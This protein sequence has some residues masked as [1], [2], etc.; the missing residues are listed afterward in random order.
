[1]NRKHHQA[2]QTGFTHI[3]FLLAVVF[4]GSLLIFVLTKNG[5][6]GSI[7]SEVP[8]N[9]VQNSSFENWNRSMPQS[10]NA[11]KFDVSQSSD[12][13]TGRY[14]LSLSGFNPTSIASS[15][16]IQQPAVVSQ[17]ISGLSANTT[18]TL[19]LYTK[20]GGG[21]V[22]F[23]YTYSLNGTTGKQ[24]VNFPPFISSPSYKITSY[25]FQLPSNLNSIYGTLGIKSNGTTPVQIDDISLTAQ[26]SPPPPPPPLTYKACQNN[27]CATVIGVGTSTCSLDTDCTPPPTTYKTCQNNACA[28][29][30]GVGANT[31]ATDADCTPPPSTYRTCQNNA[32]VT[33]TGTGNSSCST[34]ADCAPAGVL[35]QVNAPYFP[36]TGPIDNGQ[37]YPNNYSKTAVFWFGTVNPNSAYTD[38][39]VGYNDSELFFNFMTIDSDLQYEQDRTSSS[40]KSTF[41]QNDSVSVFLNFAGTTF[42]FDSMMH[43][44]E[45][46]TNYQLAY[47]NGQ[48]TALPFTTTSIWRG[49]QPDNSAGDNGWL[50][51]IDIPWSSLGLTSAP[52]KGTM[53]KIAAVTHNKNSDG[54]KPDVFWPETYSTV[55]PGTWGDLRFGEVSYAAPAATNQQTVTIKN[56]PTEN[57]PFS[58]SSIIDTILG[59]STNCGDPSLHLPGSYNANWGYYNYGYPPHDDGGNIQEY[60]TVQN[61]RDPGDWPCFSKYIGTYKLSAIPAGKKIVKAT[62]TLSNYGHSGWSGQNNYPI[63]VHILPID[64][65]DPKAAWENHPGGATGAVTQ[66]EVSWN[67]APLPAQNIG[68]TTNPIPNNPDGC[69][70]GTTCNTA[71]YCTGTG[72]VS[73]C[74]KV[75]FDLSAAVADAY[76]AGQPLRFFLYTSDFNL[77]SGEY[78]ISSTRGS[79]DSQDRPFLTVTFGE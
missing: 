30:T 24:V 18:Y 73:D 47:K 43:W 13:L 9:L 59:G 20:G 27:A 53:W 56:P 75:N 58:S 64:P 68:S 72:H 3:V 76:A 67:N 10:W 42:R 14:A 4:I 7:N 71:I 29:V 79:W 70:V 17:R 69:V 41:T 52:A 78:Y 45:N 11:Q 54:Q 31:C 2:S 16:K 22:N 1:M 19:S 50:T 23:T 60:L 74:Q 26:T 61:Q 5:Y 38:V 39:R 66:T 28:T 8:A 44:W 57:F 40:S 12:K 48:I 32:C 6:F 46:R 62:L 25:N 55:N 21:S 35:R 65:R 34:D 51:N 33:V 36:G 49:D 77:S 15:K 63:F 37:Q